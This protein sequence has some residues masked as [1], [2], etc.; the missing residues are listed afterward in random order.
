MAEGPESNGFALAC[1]ALGGFSGFLCENYRHHDYL[2]G[3]RNCQQFLRSHFSLPID[4]KPVM[5][6]VNP[7]LKQPGSPWLTSGGPPSLPIIP[8]IGTLA[9]EEPLPAW[10]KSKYDPASLQ[11][12]ETRRLDAVLDNV[13]RNS[14]QLNW[15]FRWA[16]KLGLAKVRSTLVDKSIEVVTAQ[17]RARGLL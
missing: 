17:L 11:D 6:V 1:G 15:F 13:L 9:Q 8:L 12:P 2:L 16:A 5:S 10:Q 7:C 4:N 14:V 3:R